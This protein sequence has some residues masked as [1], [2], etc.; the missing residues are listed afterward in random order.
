MN[1]EV[2]P[3]QRKFD[4]CDPRDRKIKRT[5]RPEDDIKK[6][7]YKGSRSIL[8]LNNLDKKQVNETGW[9]EFIIQN[10]NVTIP[11]KHTTYWCSLIKVPEFKSKHHIKM[12][13][14]YVQKGNE[15]VVHHLL[16]YECHGKYNESHYGLG[17]IVTNTPNMPFEE[18]YSSSVVAAWAIGGEVGRHWTIVHMLFI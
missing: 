7:T 14:P 3:E 6:H 16:I 8:L 2:D 4:T 12:F 15:G 11:K 1:N 5:P 10:K 13:E 17:S 18:C 9:K